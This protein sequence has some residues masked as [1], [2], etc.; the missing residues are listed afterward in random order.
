MTALDFLQLNYHAT[1]PLNILITPSIIEKYNR[2]FTFSLKVFRASTITKRMYEPLKNG[3]WHRTSI[4]DTICLYRFQLDQFMT[5][6][7]GYIHDTAIQTTWFR[8]IQHVKNMPLT[9]DYAV[10]MEPYAFREYHEH[11][12]DCILYQCF[13]KKSQTTVMEVLYAV[14]H[15]IIIFGAVLDDYTVTDSVGEEKLLMKCR[16][17][18]EQFE[19][20]TKIFVRVLRVLEEK[21]SGRLSNILN[22]TTSNVFKDLYAKHERNLGV[23]VFVR[24]LLVRLNL[25]GFL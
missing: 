12:L 15:D 16:L 20:H 21:G 10:I 23:D 18:F 25:N 6:V 4:R 9:D 7:Q 8:F 14:M 2:I 1:Y 5:A 24:D 13:S 11:V 3:V 17:I 19:K 22:T